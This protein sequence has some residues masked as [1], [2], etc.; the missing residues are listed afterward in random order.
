M[1]AVAAHLDLPRPGQQDVATHSP[2][3]E[4]RRQ[5][6]MRTDGAGGAI[7]WVLFRLRERAGTVLAFALAFRALDVVLLGPLVAAALRLFLLRWGRASVGNLKIAAFLLSP[8]GLAALVAVGGVALVG[9]YLELAGLT[10][11]LG[12]RRLA[13]W[14]GLTGPLGALPRLVR[15]GVR[16]LGVL[17]L[18]AAP[19]LAA[20]GL[21]YGS[22]WRGRDL[23][24]L[25]VLKPPVFWAGAG[26]AAALG[27]AYAALAFRLVLRWLLAVPI[28]LFE[29]GTRAVEALRL[30]ADR[31]EGRRAT[32]AAAV[33]TW[34]ALHALLSAAV[35]GLL[36]A[37]SGWVLGRV[38]P[39]LAVALP[40]TAGLLALHALVVAALAILGTVSFAALLLALYRWA[41]GAGIA[42]GRE[43]GATAA[44][45]RGRPGEHGD[46]AIVGGLAVLVGLTVATGVGLLRRLSLEDRIEITAH[47]AGATRGPENTVAALRRAIADRADWAEVD[48]QRT[49][50]D[51]LVVTHDTDL[52][53]LGGGPRPVGRAT[54]AEIRALDIGTP[55]GPEFA[56]ERVP[57]LEE[58][59]EAA[60]DAIRLN[61]EL[62]PHGP[63]DEGPLTERV[64]A[65]IRRAGMVGRCRVCSQSYAALQLARRLEPGLP[66]A[67]SPGRRS[68]T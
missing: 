20:I 49:A 54:L 61:V 67:T 1:R 10:R 41:D 24:G 22:L 43:P 35:L 29:P 33:L 52:A 7:A 3:Q 5:V 4:T 53:R 36:R 21:V 39:R 57:T 26:L 42:G 2:S 55:F 68:A 50:D 46:T 51:A 63:D 45:P 64:V 32:L 28:V 27:A 34:A 12:D 37:G 47:R 65:A 25:I 15:L 30:S 16:Q 59:L 48:V 19:F 23:N 17:L 44:G 8:V 9:L 56:G 62:K 14:Q 11:L 6:V 40:A 13:W 38:G 66:S 58:V 18:L 60:G 31:T